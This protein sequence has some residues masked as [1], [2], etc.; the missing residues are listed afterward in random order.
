MI[1]IKVSPD[2]EHL[3]PIPL[4]N[5]VFQYMIR[6]ISS[7]FSTFF[8]ASQIQSDMGSWSA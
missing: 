1:I 4:L 8:K 5:A 7:H 2:K 6:K 3:I